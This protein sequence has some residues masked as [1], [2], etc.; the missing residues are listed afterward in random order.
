[1]GP[2]VQQRVCRSGSAP[3]KIRTSRNL[4]DL[5]PQHL[6]RDMR[7]EPPSWG[8][9]CPPRNTLKTRGHEVQDP[10]VTDRSRRWPRRS[11][12]LTR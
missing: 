11:T 5:A 9:L 6:H 3:A 8:Q 2:I 12:D 10:A 1:M 4:H 7:C